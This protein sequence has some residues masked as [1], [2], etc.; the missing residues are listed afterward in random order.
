MSIMAGFRASDGGSSL[1]ARARAYNLQTQT[2]PPQEQTSP[3]LIPRFSNWYEPAL[4]D[5]RPAEMV[6]SQGMMK[7]Y[8]YQTLPGY[9][10]PLPATGAVG[11]RGFGD[12]QTMRAVTLNRENMRQRSGAPGIVDVV[13]SGF[14][15][16][17]TGIAGSQLL[18]NAVYTPRGRE[19]LANIDGDPT[20]PPTLGDLVGM[21]QAVWDGSITPGQ[22][23]AIT[24][25]DYMDTA[26]RLTGDENR[27]RLDEYIEADTRSRLTDPSNTRGLGSWL[28]GLH[29]NFNAFDETQKDSAFGQGVGRWITGGTDAALM[30]FV[31]ADVL[32]A[33]G[34]G[35]GYRAAT[36]KV[37]SESGKR[38]SIS[39][40][41][42][43]A[44]YL[45]G[46]AGIKETA[47]YELIDSIFRLTP[48]QAAFHPLVEQSD[49]PALAAKMFG[50]KFNSRREAL[51]A[52][53]AAAGDPMAARRLQKSRIDL[54]DEM[55]RSKEEL[56]AMRWNI[57][58]GADLE[59]LTDPFDSEFALFGMNMTDENLKHLDDVAT[60]AK[61]EY[62]R[63]RE[64]SDFTTGRFQDEVLVKPL[65]G[66]YERGFG[67]AIRYDKRANMTSRRSAAGM[68]ARSQR[69]LDKFSG[70]AY[71]HS[72]FGVFGRPIRYVEMNV[73]SKKDYLGRHR[74]TGVLNFQDHTEFLA[75]FKAALSTTPFLRRAAKAKAGSDKRLIAQVDKNGKITKVDVEV[76]RTRLLREA[77]D[78]AA[79]SP[80]DKAAWIESFEMQMADALGQYLSSSNRYRNLPDGVTRTSLVE[81]A[82]KYATKRS[83]VRAHIQNHSW[84][85]DSNELVV[86]D[87]VT[88]ATQRNGYTLMDFHW[89]ERTFHL[90]MGG[91]VKEG[92]AQGV[93]G[94][95]K[96][97]DYVW[98]PV[99]L[100][101][102]GYTQ[103]NLA[104]GWLRT[105]A[106]MGEIPTTG[107][108]GTSSKN[109]FLN[110][111][112]RIAGGF[113][114][115]KNWRLKRRGL[116][117]IRKDMAILQQ[118]QQ[119]QLA[120]QAT[121]REEYE[122][123]ARELKQ[124]RKRLEREA[125]DELLARTRRTMTA[126]ETPVYSQ[127]A[128]DLTEAQ[129]AMLDTAD[130]LI[131]NVG[132]VNS[133]MARGLL[134]ADE[135][136]G[137]GAA[138]VEALVRRSLGEDAVDFADEFDSLVTFMTPRQRAAYSDLVESNFDE[139]T[140]AMLTDEAQAQAESMM[141]DAYF[142]RINQLMK[143]DYRIGRIG[144][145]GEFKTVRSD[146][147]PNL[148]LDDLRSGSI[149]AVPKSVKPQY[150]KADVY[151]GVLDLRTNVQSEV[152]N[153]ARQVEQAKA[154]GVDQLL[155]VNGDTAN[156]Q[157]I[158][159]NRLR[160]L[161]GDDFTD[162]VTSR[163]VEAQTPLD[164]DAVVSRTLGE[165]MRIV[166]NAFAAIERDP[167]LLRAIALKRWMDN[168]ADRLPEGFM[169][170]AAKKRLILSNKELGRILRT[171]KRTQAQAMTAKQRRDD[172]LAYLNDDATWNELTREY[173][174]PIHAGRELPD[175]V[176]PDVL[177]NE[178]TLRYSH[179]P[180]LYSIVD[181]G[182]TSRGYFMAHVR[183]HSDV[184]A[185]VPVVYAMPDPRNYAWID[186]DAPVTLVD[187]SLNP[188]FEDLVA[189]FS[190]KTFTIARKPSSFDMLLP[191]SVATN[192]GGVVGKT[193]GEVIMS[194]A[195][196]FNTI[197]GAYNFIRRMASKSL[198]ADA[199]GNVYKAIDAL[200]KGGYDG[201]TYMSGVEGRG[202][203]GWWAKDVPMIRVDE[204]SDAGLDLLATEARIGTLNA[205]LD[206]LALQ[207]GAA[208]TMANT[209]P[210]SLT[211]TSR[212][213]GM[214]YVPNA[215]LEQLL[216]QYAREKGY[217]KVLLDDRSTVEGYRALFVPDMMAT[218][219]GFMDSLI[220]GQVAAAGR[221]NA[222]VLDIAQGSPSLQALSE[223]D[224]ELARVITRR[225]N[226]SNANRA[227][228]AMFM[229]DRN[230]THILLPSVKGGEPVLT[231]ASELL[232]TT[233][234]GLAYAR[235]ALKD[236]VDELRA[237]K[238]SKS[239]EYEEITARMQAAKQN[240]ERLTAD[241]GN[242]RETLRDLSGALDRVRTQRTPRRSVTDGEVEIT[243][244]SGRAKLKTGEVFDENEAQS[245][246]YISMA[247]SGSFHDLLL[248]GYMQ[249]RYAQY[250]RSY[251]FVEYTPGNDKYWLALSNLVNENIRQEPILRRL[252]GMPRVRL[253]DE[254]AIAAQNESIIDDLMKDD[255]FRSGADTGLYPTKMTD[256][257]VKTVDEENLIGYEFEAFPDDLA[258]RINEYREKLYKWLPDDEVMQAAA[259]GKVM[260]DYLASRMAWRT[261]LVNI[262]EK[263]LVE[264]GN[265]Y[266]RFINRGMNLLGT[267]PEDHMIRHPFYRKRWMEEMQRQTDVYEANGIE[268]FSQAQIDAMRRSAHDFALKTTRSTLYTV[269]RLSTPAAVLGL[270]IPFFPA[271]ENALRFWT[272]ALFTRPENMMRYVQ[273]WNAPNAMGM[274]VDQEGNPIEAK[275][276]LF[277][278]PEALFAPGGAQIQFTLP[279]GLTEKIPD[280]PEWLPD[281]APWV[282]VGTYG[283]VRVAKGA[284]NVA[285][286]GDYPWLTN[287]GP[288]VTTPLSYF[289]AMKP[290]YTQAVLDFKPGGLSVGEAVA[291]QFVPFGRPTAE[292]DIWSVLSENFTPAT[293]QRMITQFRGMSDPEFAGT[294]EEIRRDMT[295]DW[296]LSNREGPEPTMEEAVARAREVFSLRAVANFT[297]FA[298]PSFQSK[299]QGE[300]EEWRRINDKHRELV[301]S[302]EKFNVPLPEDTPMGYQAAL[303]EFLDLHGKAFFYLT[304]S[305][306]GR[307]GIGASVPEYQII[308]KYGQL[309]SDLAGDGSDDWVAMITSPYADQF[310][311]AVYANQMNRQ[312]D[313]STTLMRGGNPGDSIVKSRVQLGWILYRDGMNALDAMLEEAGFTSY[314]QSGAETFKD[315]KDLLVADV[316]SQYPE[317][318]EQRLKFDRGEW[319]VMI[320]NVEMILDNKEFMRDHG[321]EPLWVDVRGWLDARNDMG[322]LLVQRKREGGSSNIDAS[323]NIDLR[324]AW[325]LFIF[326]L[327]QK[328]LKFSEFYNRFLDYDTLLP[329][330]PMDSLVLSTDVVE[331]Q[332]GPDDVI[333]PSVPSPFTMPRGG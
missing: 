119:E 52:F 93:F 71:T 111:G 242:R 83:I 225:G 327:R 123:A 191:D 223:F 104:E 283:Q 73:R 171:T 130:T 81:A 243:G 139:T 4:A 177:V 224:P 68:E 151:G 290:D 278:V 275:R 239:T 118:T 13:D 29:S 127:I 103:R 251:N 11:T 134:A 107:H 235:L 287:F 12:M 313:N 48:E 279:T 170:W 18:L 321:E 15:G 70:S 95:L 92:A 45:V 47:E 154:D 169:E 99:V 175:D 281:W 305:S 84:I 153:V 331:P 201:F 246:Q 214:D 179:G 97:L 39:F 26:V 24:F 200:R 270:L 264:I 207:E 172:L 178:R 306:S 128:D 211:T 212:A 51:D 76:F 276:G 35:A 299:Y 293:V 302:Y 8:D 80:K 332:P 267:L 250:E 59:D 291:K 147:L 62:E 249:N 54:Y 100:L 228:L 50:A 77:I 320:R 109:F 131:Y 273:A 135:S 286:Q 32:I 322:D 44:N 63:V 75:E 222:Q 213:P 315:M 27:R 108:V 110:S 240:L 16:F 197:G 216:V 258:G 17:N 256:R 2:Q 330:D 113:N 220:P 41:E 263:D 198:G 295:I 160:S 78:A 218:N 94:F 230:Y 174:L 265:R 311:Y 115:T 255:A 6:E 105:L 173:G 294:V 202:A 42:F 192:P 184:K 144:K 79:L 319:K 165:A 149:V 183:G 1:Y 210:E 87:E 168:N 314:Q 236:D 120:R 262:K 253:D 141:L 303:R 114:R 60:A 88:L 323:S 101:R 162:Y 86:L 152:F 308:N 176:L 7:A 189:I 132:D 55:V 138:D 150:A 231:S 124:L 241:I 164:N 186:L 116:K 271:W 180:G 34:I 277:G 64:F 269:T 326:D 30:W 98:R 126:W 199:E 166:D 145:S 234:S 329:G 65:I 28:T 158:A 91:P 257:A 36:T 205:R 74:Q 19:R 67:R 106:A 245:G 232:A 284:L 318:D 244:R 268:E 254:A 125:R 227:K 317:W 182:P 56:D 82:K 310:S 188:Q 288:I 122:K 185:G 38:G 159:S 274:V 296:E 163:T 136:T 148:T 43:Q 208:R 289:A 157:V 20:N 90:H 247:S 325:D 248:V 143:A 301:E 33:K 121:S 219:E 259:K 10:M 285:L 9:A 161:F 333:R 61:A 102:L 85:K 22:A 31:G 195:D 190:D 142:R 194:S 282:S 155:W 140:G 203:Y 25:G 196:S 129:L 133:L 280:R 46:A 204:L 260:P 233:K 5:G 137:F 112:D 237:L 146:S 53:L 307:S 209:S 72:V 226:L 37:L 206:N 167:E 229:Q 261:D 298:A 252:V 69:R 66:R 193:I 187:N 57:N 292:K 328:N 3:G 309:A 221:G 217:G 238:M 14:R 297:A 21:Y 58:K 316:A 215:K 266:R 181:A 40:D 23:I 49:N 300:I 117:K 96:A 304:Q 312:F 324:T 272:K 89:L 156:L